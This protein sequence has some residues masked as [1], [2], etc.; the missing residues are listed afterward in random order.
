MDR[1]NN[2]VVNVDFSSGIIA[3]WTNWYNATLDVVD[4]RLRVTKNAASNISVFGQPKDIEVNTTDVYYF[5]CNFES[6]SVLNYFRLTACGRRK[7]F[8]YHQL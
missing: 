8:C 7:I 6:S 2:I 4:G 3:P 1:P 5:A